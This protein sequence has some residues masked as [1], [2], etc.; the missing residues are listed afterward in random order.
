MYRHKSVLILFV[1]LFWGTVVSYAQPRLLQ[2]EIYVGA[3]G[4][5]LAS[6]ANFSPSVAQTAKHPFLGANAGLI[7]RYYGQKYC[8]LEINLNYMQRGWRE[9][10]TGYRRELGYI[11]LPF[12]A[13]IYFGKKVRGYVNLG[14]QI[15]YCIYE[16]HYGDKGTGAQYNPIEKPFDWGLAGGVGMYVRTGKA[17]VWQLG[18]RFNYSFG[19]I[20]STRKTDYFS[21]A[22]QM[23][24][25]LNIGWLWQVK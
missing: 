25:S 21:Q 16:K 14:P 4:G 5:V 18:A 17:G 9:K 7:F 20:F 6:M 24:L 11:E 10:D 23:N 19:A 12:L 3:Q 8:G 1:V 22:N 13:H 2:P 15:G